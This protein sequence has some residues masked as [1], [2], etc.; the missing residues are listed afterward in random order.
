M[1]CLVRE[2]G[3]N[4]ATAFVIQYNTHESCYI[5][6]GLFVFCRFFATL[7]P[8][9]SKNYKLGK[10]APRNFFLSR[11]LARWVHLARLASQSEHRIRFILSTGAADDRINVKIEIL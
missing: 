7:W 2:P 4:K 5:F 10:F 6:F 1:T 9:L 11:E 3:K 8:T